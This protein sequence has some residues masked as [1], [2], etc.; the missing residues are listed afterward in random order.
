MEDKAFILEQVKQWFS[1]SIAANHIKNTL[2]LKKPKEFDINPFLSIY[3]A[4][5][6]TGDASAHSIA[7]ALVLPRVLGT[8]ITTSFGQN[9]QSFI[10]ILRQSYGST[11]S[12]IDIEFHDHVDGNKKYCQL[13]AGP[14]TIN[15][16]DVESIAGHFIGVINLAKTNNLRIHRDDM[17]VGV[18]Y[19][20]QSDLSSHYKR[21]MSQYDHPVITGADFWYRLTGDV[22][23]YNDLIEAITSVA[24]E[25]D[26]SKQ[27]DEVIDELAQT[28][29]IKSLEK[30]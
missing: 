13:K 24:T 26:F 10:S 7:K 2:K 30:L 18:L 27:L 16:D 20:E 12:G 28:E 23:F 15:K 29:T 14:N 11:T 25:S 22:D 21:I 3:L 4:K 19:G 9:M 1:Q 5:F 17:I 6:L 8:S